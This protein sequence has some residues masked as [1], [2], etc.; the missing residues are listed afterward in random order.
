MKSLYSLTF[1]F[2]L[3]LMN[4]ITFNAQEINTGIPDDMQEMGIQL[5][6]AADKGDSLRVSQLLA[7]GADVNAT[8]YDS[9][10]ALMYAVQSGNE[11]MVRYLV[12]SGAAVNMVPDNGYSALITAITSRWFSIAE[13]L[14]RHG[15]NIE[16]S[17]HDDV[18]PLMHAVMADSFYMA[19]L[20]MYYGANVNHKS[21]SGTTALMLASELGSYQ[22]AV[23]LLEEGAD[24]N[25][26]D[27]KGR[28]PLHFATMTSHLE[29]MDLLIQ[30]GAAVD[31]KMVNGYSPLSI[32]VSTN[33]FEAARLLIGYGADV[34]SRVNRSMNPLTIAR[35]KKYDSLAAML[36]NNEAILIRRPD[37][38][39][40]SFGTGLTFNK[41]DM[42][43]GFSLGICDHRYNIWVSLGYGFR[44]AAIRVLEGPIDFNY[45]QYWERRHVLG[46]SA[47][48]GFFLPV[49]HKGFKLG[50]YAGFREMIT[51]GS[52]RGSSV[53]PDTR[54]VLNPHV[55]VVADFH[56]LRLKLGYEYLNFRINRINNNHVGISLE[57]LLYRRKGNINLTTSNW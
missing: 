8:T 25:D 14:I 48:K 10:T 55:G 26:S 53:A 49:F 18:S 43:V 3:L 17:D 9:V 51:F 30:N 39:R 28:T 37:F 12:S 54:L 46:F 6:M 27:K 41:D 31:R 40:L 13:Y 32:A 24:V 1:V 56:M 15:A 57:W 47:D 52:Y 2:L 5:I 20:L 34:N 19:D 38:N 22:V 29:L 45:Y 23:R 33:N 21:Q 42:L 44:P 36:R 7:A 50:A 16:L 4:T 35:E 11:G